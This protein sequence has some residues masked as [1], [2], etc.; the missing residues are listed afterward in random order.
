MPRL[1]SCVVARSEAGDPEAMFSLKTFK[2]F[3]H[4]GVPIEW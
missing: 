4:Y 2:A 3:K 1:T